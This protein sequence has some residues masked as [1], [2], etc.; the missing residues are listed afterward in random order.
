VPPIEVATGG[1]ASTS[2][3]RDTSAMRIVTVVLRLVLALDREARLILRARGSSRFD[4]QCPLARPFDDAQSEG[5]KVFP[6]RLLYRL[7]SCRAK[8]RSATASAR[9]W[10]RALFFI[11]GSYPVSTPPRCL[12][13]RRAGRS[14]TARDSLDGIPGRRVAGGSRR[15]RASGAVRGDVAE[16][17]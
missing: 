7:R 16:L 10:A 11:S 13:T 14:P 6:L 4:A 12:S 5:Q 3:A 2:T 8:S 1:N 9:A 15:R 17:A